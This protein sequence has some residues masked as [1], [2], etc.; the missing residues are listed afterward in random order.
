[1]AQFLDARAA[2][3]PGKYFIYLSP[4]GSVYFGKVRWIE[5][6]SE[7]FKVVLLELDP[8]NVIWCKLNEGI[9][10]DFDQLLLSSE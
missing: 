1:M 6:T 8:E 5:E 3:D 2:P 7:K 4:A 10:A 9:W